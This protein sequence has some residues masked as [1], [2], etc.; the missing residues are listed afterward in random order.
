MQSLQA[1]VN[2]SISDS[3]LEFSLRHTDVGEG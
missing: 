1:V 3:Q 2:K